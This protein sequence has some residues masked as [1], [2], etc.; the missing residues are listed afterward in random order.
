MLTA[1]QGPQVGGCINPDLAQSDSSQPSA[2]KIPPGLCR[3]QATHR[4]CLRLGDTG[5]KDGAQPDPE[6]RRSAACAH[7]RSLFIKVCY[8]KNIS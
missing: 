4:C 8:Y 2:P 7:G 1:T 6:G 5:R 3:S